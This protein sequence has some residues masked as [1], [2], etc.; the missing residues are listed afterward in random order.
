M[1]KRKERINPLEETPNSPL[2]YSD[3]ENSMIGDKQQMK[4]K[5]FVSGCSSN[6]GVY[7]GYYGEYGDCLSHTVGMLWGDWRVCCDAETFFSWCQKRLKD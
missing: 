5:V 1:E 6:H 7:C 3:F 4:K 2:P